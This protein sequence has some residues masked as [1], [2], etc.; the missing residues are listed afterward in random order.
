MAKFL[1]A[2]I[3]PATGEVETDLDGYKGKGCHA[4]QDA[5]T[6]ALGGEVKSEVKKPEFNAVV[7]NTVCAKR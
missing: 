3:D 2:T 1:T 4:V 5:I 6:A 7:T